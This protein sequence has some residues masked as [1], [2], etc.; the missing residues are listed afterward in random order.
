MAEA[1]L[2]HVPKPVLLPAFPG[3]HAKEPVDE[4]EQQIVRA[5]V[6]RVVQLQTKVESVRAALV[7]KVRVYKD[8]LEE[9]S[10]N[11]LPAEPNVAGVEEERL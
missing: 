9:A 7:V 5:L 4:E 3:V 6:R 2:G 1:V 10:V 11:M 8:A